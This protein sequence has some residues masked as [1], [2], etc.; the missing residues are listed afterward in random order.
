MF[1][2][3]RFGTFPSYVTVPVIVA[4]AK[5]ELPRTAIASTAAAA[6]RKR[7]TDMLIS[8]FPHLET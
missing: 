4:A 7:L 5:A 3:G 1:S 2:G 8:L 6:V